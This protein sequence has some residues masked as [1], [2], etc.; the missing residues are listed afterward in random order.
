M[1]RVPNQRVHTERERTLTLE[2][3]GVVT[4]DLTP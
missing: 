2:S 4:L 3:G 1:V